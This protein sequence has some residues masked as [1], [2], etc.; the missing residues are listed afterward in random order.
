MLNSTAQALNAQS[1]A[2]GVTSNNI[3]NL[4][5]PNY[6]DEYVVFGTA[7]EVMTPQGEEDTGLQAT[8][9]QQ[10]S[11]GL[12]NQQIMTQSGLVSSDS[13][14][15]G[16]LQQAQAGLGESLTNAATSTSSSSTS[17]T[18]S[19]LGLSLSNF[20]NGFTALAAQPNDSGTQQALI[21]QA[22]TLTQNFQSIDQNLAQVQ[23]AASTQAASDVTSANTLLAGIATLNIQI[24]AAEVNSPGSAVSLRDNREADLEK[25]AAILPINVKEQSNGE[26]TVST[27]DASGNPVVLVTQGRVQGSLAYANGM[28]TGGQPPTTLGLGAGSIQGAITASTGPI[29][30]LRSSID[31]LASQLVTAVNAAYNPSGTGANFFNPSGTTAGTISLAAGLNSSTLVA[32]TGAAG[33]NSIATAVAALANTTY[34]TSAGDAIDGTFASYYANTVGNFG[35]SITNVTA[36]L[37]DESNV[38]TLLTSQRNGISGVSMDQEMSNLVQFQQAYVASSET[39][40]IVN[41]ILGNEITSMGS[42]SG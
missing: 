28:V 38:Q 29:Q 40:N 33:D 13:A 42:S 1:V 19:G 17:T 24:G 8:S 9:V 3:A 25:L 37:D 2:I 20:M 22:T 23:A 31:S 12:L 30:S 34:S 39:F 14:Q 7:G 32:G 27:P 41:Q 4:N 26:D 16:W 15:Q 36:N 5:N 35:Q 10:Y 6:A 18:D 21:E 11:D